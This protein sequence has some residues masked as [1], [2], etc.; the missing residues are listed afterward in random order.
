MSLRFETADVLARMD[1]LRTDS[2]VSSSVAHHLGD[3][4]LVRFI[5]WMDRYAAHG[6]FINDLQRHILPYFFIKYATRFLPVNRMARH[7]GP[8]SVARAFAADDLRHL[9]A[10]AGIGGRAGVHRMVPSLSLQRVVQKRDRNLA[11]DPAL[12]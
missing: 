9:L 4:N 5:R 11:A 3:A 2:I 7:D 12:P 1:P 8:V 6:W 10:D